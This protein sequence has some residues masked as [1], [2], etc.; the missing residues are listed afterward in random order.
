M[1]YVAGALAVAAGVFSPIGLHELGRFW[2]RSLH[3]WKHVLRQTCLLA[4]R[5]WLGRRM[6]RLCERA[7]NL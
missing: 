7:I 4:R 5:G 3:I 2:C 1:Y 6:G